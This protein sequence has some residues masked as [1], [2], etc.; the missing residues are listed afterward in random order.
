MTRERAMR[1]RT[2]HEEASAILDDREMLEAG[3]E[4][5]LWGRARR[6]ALLTRVLHVYLVASVVILVSSLAGLFGHD[7][8]SWIPVAAGAATV[9]TAWTI[10]RMVE[11]ATTDLPVVEHRRI[12]SGRLEATGTAVVAYSWVVLAAGVACVVSGLS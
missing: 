7:T 12:E 8:A 3:K 6:V 11:R 10:G 2:G 1:I 5:E 9:P 4:F